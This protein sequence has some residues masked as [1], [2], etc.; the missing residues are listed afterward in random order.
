MVVVFTLWFLYCFSFIFIFRT[1]FM[2][3]WV[4]GPKRLE[5]LY[6]FWMNYNNK[7]NIN[8]VKCEAETAH[9]SFFSFF[10]I[11]TRGFLTEVLKEIIVNAHLPHK[12]TNNELFFLCF[13]FFFCFSIWTASRYG[14]VVF[15]VVEYAECVSSLILL[16]QIFIIRLLLLHYGWFHLIFCNMVAHSSHTKI[17]K[18]FQVDRIRIQNGKS[19]KRQ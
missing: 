8:A 1:R 12:P 11:I 10:F 7:N 2:G 5:R 9:F 3:L 14:G 15:I 6:N 17:R 18:V 16:L 4:C 19:C 13:L